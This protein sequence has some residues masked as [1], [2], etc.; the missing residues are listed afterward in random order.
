MHWHFSRC[1][2][3]KKSVSS[4]NNQSCK[5]GKDEP[6]VEPPTVEPK[7]I[8]FPQRTPL[9]ASSARKGVY[10]ALQNT[11][12]ASLRNQSTTTGF[13]PGFEAGCIH[14]HTLSCFCKP[15][16]CPNRR[17]CCGKQMYKRCNRSLG[18][19]EPDQELPSR[20]KPRRPIRATEFDFRFRL[21]SFWSSCS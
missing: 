3:S 9:V 2:R 11:I 10:R 21:C 16:M 18:R 12:R 17:T 8:L 19:R 13:S 7:V 5:P 15:P 14:R 6:N 20:T 1:H 4:Q